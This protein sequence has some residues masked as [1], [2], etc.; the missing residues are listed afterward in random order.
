MGRPS[1]PATPRSGDAGTAAGLPHARR[2][3]RRDRHT[4]GCRD[5]RRTRCVHRL[6]PGDD[7]RIDRLWGRDEGSAGPAE[8][9]AGRGGLQSAPGSA[10]PRAR[11]D[12]G[13]HRRPHARVDGR[14]GPG[15]VRGGRPRRVDHAHPDEEGSAGDLALGHRRARRRAPPPNHLLRGHVDLR[16]ALAPGDPGRAGAADR[17]G[18]ADRGQRAGQGGIPGR[19]RHHGHAGARRRG[20]AGRADRTAGASCLR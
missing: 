9:G 1:F 8:P 3:R 17:L 12:G 16:G 20:G 19:P 15:P 2:R 14:R 13:E 10:G 5:L 6:L 4:H 7:D 11:R 18:G